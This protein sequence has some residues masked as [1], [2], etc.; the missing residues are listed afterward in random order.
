[1]A[2]FD[3]N[4]ER[5]TGRSVPEWVR[6]VK[7][8]DVRKHGEIVGWLKT[9]HSLSHS[10][11]NQIAKRALQP[12]TAELGSV[13]HL[14]TGGKESLR[15]LYDRIIKIAEAFGPDVSVAPKKANVSI[16]RRKQFALVQPSTKTRIDI[17]L[18]LKGKPSGGRLEPSGSFNPMFTHRVR[19]ESAD[20]I[21]RAFQ[22]WLRQAY[23]QAG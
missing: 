16:R 21:D 8:Q 6:L 12:D 4:I 18:I 10:H 17:G 23:E 7:V 11:A 2:T 15:P 13:D 1:M 19:I 20:Q 3:S 9:T 22:D 14:F 5:R